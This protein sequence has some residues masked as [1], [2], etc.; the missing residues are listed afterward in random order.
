MPPQL[1]PGLTIPVNPAEADHGTLC[2]NCIADCV[3]YPDP[4]FLILT[5]ENGDWIIDPQARRLYARIQ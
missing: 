5:I 2:F 3:H 1:P 4:D